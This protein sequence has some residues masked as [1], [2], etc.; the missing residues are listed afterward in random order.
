QPVAV[1]T[2]GAASHRK[3][4]VS[5]PGASPPGEGSRDDTR[6]D[7]TGEPAHRDTTVPAVRAVRRAGERDVGRVRGG[8]RRPAGV[9]GTSGPAAG[10]GTALAPGAGLVEP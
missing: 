3:V 5:E 10:L 7:R 9:L 8:C 1:W 4:A 2:R 6:E